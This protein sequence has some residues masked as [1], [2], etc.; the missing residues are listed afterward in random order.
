MAAA[1]ARLPDLPSRSPTPAPPLTLNTSWKG[2]AA[3]IPNKHIPF[4][5]PGSVASY[6]LPSPPA[7]PPEKPFLAH[8]GSALQSSDAH[9][10]VSDSPPVYAINA[11]SVAEVLHHVSSRPSPE[12]DQVFPWL[13]GLHP[14]NQLQLAFFASRRGCPQ[15]TPRCLRGLTIV[16][17]GGDLGTAKL[18]G[19]VAPDELL[20]SSNDAA[21]EPVFQET[22]PKAGFSVRNFQ[23]QACK[24]ATISDLVV[25]GDDS[26]PRHQ[27]E[28]LAQCLSQAQLYHREEEAVPEEDPEEFR[29][30]IVTDSFSIFES[31]HPEVVAIDSRGTFT[32]AVLDFLAQER[33]EMCNLSKASEIAPNVW[34]GPTPDPTIYSNTAAIDE[35][36]FEVQIEASD[37]AMMPTEAHLRDVESHL[38]DE[39]AE[40]LAHLEFPSSGSFGATEN[41]TQD[42][43]DVERLL[44]LCRWLHRL[45][46]QGV[47]P[48]KSIDSTSINSNAT[49]TIEPAPR[50]C[51]ILIHCADGY[52]ESSLLALAYFMFSEGLPAHDAWIRL[53]RDKQRNFFAY[54]PDKAFLE[55]IQLRLL[56]ASPSLAHAPPALVER[57][58]WMQRLDG[59]LPSR[60]LP[61]L[62]LGNLGHAQNPDLLQ[63]L[64]ITR[65]LSVGES[66]TW[67]D[68]HRNRWGEDNFLFVDNVQ[69]N[70]VDPLTVEFERCLKFISE[71][72][73]FHGLLFRRPRAFAVVWLTEMGI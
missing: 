12:P 50:P 31:R 26:T 52:T 61:Y 13:H 65:V 56:E 8:P 14:G 54:P 4:C 36:Q 38:A 62:Y 48:H 5:S 67:A 3:A 35:P 16:K 40:T 69:D 58:A 47:I 66:I 42:E 39:T 44:L 70:G 22:D 51:R 15:R 43:A 72:G 19:A 71:L 34:L 57:P 11:G 49:A 63:Q 41:G 21:G 32:G 27:V 20:I 2:S 29:T 17:A 6:G 60:I 1:V 9:H 64:G 33:L 30:F 59:S 25:Y 28:H 55:N 53:H 18:K 37:F 23:I 10:R 46:N 24:M 68:E 7:T 45:S 73:Y